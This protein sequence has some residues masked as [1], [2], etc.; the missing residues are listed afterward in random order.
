MQELIKRLT[1][2]TGITEAQAAQAIEIM[3]KYIK[4]QVPPMMHGAVDNFI[5]KG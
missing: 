2:N 5:K 1:E 3:V 4:E